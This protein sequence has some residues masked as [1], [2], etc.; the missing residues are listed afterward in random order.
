MREVKLLHGRIKRLMVMNTHWDVVLGDE[1]EESDIMRP[2]FWDVV[3]KD[4]TPGDII[5]VRTDTGEFYAQYYVVSCGR[6]N[7][8]LKQIMRLDLEETDANDIVVSEYRYKW[9]G[10]KLKHCVVRASDGERVMTNLPTKGE[11][12]KWIGG[13]HKAA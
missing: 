6:F 1:H 4:F 8:H 2:E 9:C 13:Q 7:A 12:L 3:S 11:A 10:P 5:H